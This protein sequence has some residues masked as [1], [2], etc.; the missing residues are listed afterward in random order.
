MINKDYQHLYGPVPS[1][2][3]GSSLGVD[4]IPPKICTYDC[5]YCQLS[6]TTQKTLERKEYVPVDRVLAELERKL[7]EKQKPAYISLAGSGEPTL[8][9][10]IGPLIRGIK[11]MTEIPVTVLTNGSILWMDEVRKD[12]MEADIV[13]PSLD[14]GGPHEFEF[15]NRPCKGISYQKMVEG[16]IEFTRDFPGRVW[17]EVL[18]VGGLTDKVSK[19]KEIAAQAK[20][21]NP[22][23]IQLNTVC[24]PPVEQIALALAPEKMVE[25]SGFFSGEVEIISSASLRDYPDQE[26]RDA[27]DMEILD[28]ISRRPCTADDV[29]SGLGIHITEA[30]KHL[31]AL[32]TRNRIVPEETGGLHFYRLADSAEERTVSEKDEDK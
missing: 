11:N 2:R 16:L 5:I 31:K 4:I 23:I 1:R 29:A 15:V 19:V 6:R 21:I 9:S 18:L 32:D 27:R 17:L 28:L 26:L 22:D 14:A 30:I 10:G 3:L 13:L 8:N 7:A 20:R 12:L 25:M 24:R